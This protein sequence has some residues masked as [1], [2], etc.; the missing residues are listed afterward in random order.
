MKSYFE[1]RIV[2]ELDS[3]GEV[4]IAGRTWPN[5]HV[6]ENVE[7]D[8]F[9]AYV[10]ERFEQK[11]VLAKE[12][13][14]DFLTETGCLQRFE[15]LCDKK[16]RQLVMPFVGAGMSAASG[17]PL[18]SK[19]LLRLCNDSAA[20][21]AEVTDYLA[22][23]LF[24]EAAQAVADLFGVDAL[25]GDIEAQLGRPG[26]TVQGAVQLLPHSF[27]NGCITTNLDNVLERSYRENAERFDSEI[28]GENLREQPGFLSPDENN[29]FKLHG[30]ATARNGR[31]VTRD[32]YQNTYDNNVSL[33]QVL[34]AIVS[35][36]HLLFLGCSLSV[37]RTVQALVD[38]RQAA[39]LA[40]P[41]H[42]AFL[43]LTEQTNR[44]E[45]RLQ[46]TDANI[47]PIWY[48]CNDV[49]D[50]EQKIE[51]LLVCLAEGGPQ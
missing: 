18:W 17:F 14:V 28:W 38:I 11:K 45:R 37:D 39:A 44:E 9:R 33:S 51:D 10:D 3:E 21:H 8:E 31:V 19:F 43:P 7:P 30:T 20:L 22:Q 50:H 46:L 16:N 13:A 6:F 5:S 29:L 36:R 48:P 35:N 2:E 49:M 27:S 40:T 47:T 23:G 4:S 41:Q 12:R 26:Y 24:E 32:E 15:L 25:H 1:G 34:A 42:F